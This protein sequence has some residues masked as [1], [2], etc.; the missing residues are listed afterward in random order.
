[1]AKVT[2]N[3]ALRDPATGAI[4]VLNTGDEVP[5][6]ADGLVGPHLLEQPAGARS[7]SDK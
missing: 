1:M 6:W 7:K 2:G 4:V 3:V 5:D